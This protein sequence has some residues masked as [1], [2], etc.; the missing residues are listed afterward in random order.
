MSGWAVASVIGGLLGVLIIVLLAVIARAVRRTTENAG[1]L[2]EALED[3]RTKTAMLAD[4]EAQSEHTSQVVAEAEA[5][6][7]DLRLPDR[8]E[9]HGT[10]DR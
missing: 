5:A 8:E 9:G 1:A 4:L 7:R 2:M 10:D 6:L 3:V